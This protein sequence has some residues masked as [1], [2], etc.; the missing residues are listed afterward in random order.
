MPFVASPWSRV[1]EIVEAYVCVDDG[2]SGT[3]LDRPGLDRLRDG[4]EAGA[5]EAVLILCP[6]RLARKYAYQMLILEEFERFGARA[7]FLEQPPSEDPHARLLVQIQGAIAEYERMKITERYRRGKLFRARQGEII[8]WKVP[9]GYRRVPRRD[10]VPAHLEI[11][12]PEAQVVRQIFAWHVDDRLSVRQIALRLT[13]SAHPT[14]TGRTRWGPSTVGRLLR[15][16]AYIGT[17]YFNRHESLDGDAKTA[18]RRRRTKRRSRCRPVAEWVPLSVPPILSEELFR[19]SQA[20][21]VVNTRFSP[22]HLKSDHYLLRGVVRCRVCD[23]GSSCH[24]M[25]GRDGTFHHYYYCSGHDALRARA[26]IGRCPQRN[27]RADELD[28]LVWAEVRRHL[29]TPALIL[30][31]YTQWRAEPAPRPDDVVARE[32]R[33]LQ[34]KLTELDREEHRLIDAYQAELI[35]LDQLERRQ[36][37]LRQ[38]R[39]HLRAS[40]EATHGEHTGALQRAEL[41]LSVERFTRSICGP[42]ATLGFED[43]QR[44]VRTVIDRV[45]VEE[46]HIDIHFA[47]PVPEP[48]TGGG[49][50]QGRRVSTD[51]RLRSNGRD[52]LGVVD[53][54]I[55]ERDGTARVGEDGRPVGECQVCR[56]DQAFPFV[57]PADDLEEQVGGARVVGQIAQLVEH[58]ES[59]LAVG[60]QAA[61][62]AAGG[63]LAAE[64]EQQ[65]GGGGEQDVMAGEHGLVGDVLGDHGFAEALGG[66]EHAVAAGG[67]EVEVERGLD[68][69]PVDPRGPRPVKGVHGGDAAEA[70]AEQPALEAATGAL[71]LL[72]VGEVLEELGRTP[73]AFRGEGDEVVQVLSG[74]VQAEELEGVRKR[75]HRA[76][77]RRR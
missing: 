76:T 64:I 43:R 45:M 59:A 10:G 46:G 75:S 6:D 58:Q 42:L 70:A 51:L 2:Y 23:L 26:G 33:E 24:R 67:E 73:A 20:L 8:F 35:E 57:A 31:A 16:E 74:V 32:V 4:A 27:L 3:R 15:N 19:R 62:K 11:A 53:E 30:D 5:F 18:G 29:E 71:L 21:H 52:D 17:M 25:R 14:A 44:L 39:E 50:N 9:Y 47:I 38:R 37:L 1:H 34:K 60:V 72:D 77:P 13:E 65:L 7:M 56:E 69:G 22:R 41:A 48:P 61:G 68:G 54:A 28:N 40:L 55:D 63:L 36:R 66:D 49:P 12:E